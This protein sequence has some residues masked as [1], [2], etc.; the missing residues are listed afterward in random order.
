MD[1]QEISN[2]KNSQEKIGEI[3]TNT[4]EKYDKAKWKNIMDTT[5][6]NYANMLKRLTGR[7]KI[8]NMILIYYSIFLIVATLT[9]RYFNDIYDSYLSEYFSVIISIIIL[10]YSLVINNSNYSLRIYNLDKSLDELKNLKREIE[11]RT[12]E[13]IREKYN[14]ITGR[15]E[16]REDIDFFRTIRGQAR[17]YGLN[18]VT[19][20]INTNK[21]CF[22]EDKCKKIMEYLSELRI[23]RLYLEIIG[24]FIWHTLLFIAPILIFFICLLR[25]NWIIFSW[26]K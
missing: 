21:E 17:L 1:K 11:E 25:K 8:S 7:S 15:T 18:I 9:A 5:Q 26:F 10:A 3:S 24:E 20:K 12:L 2:N 14:E 4:N 6:N 22:N 23:Y 16:R 13:E 19:K